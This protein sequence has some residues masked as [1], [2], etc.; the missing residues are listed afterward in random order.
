MFLFILWNDDMFDGGRTDHVR[1][2]EDPTFGSTFSV[3]VGTLNVCCSQSFSSL[4]VIN[5]V[6]V[7]VNSWGWVIRRWIGRS[8]NVD[9]NVGW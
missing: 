4:I 1:E 7:K 8:L 6:V 9:W 2:Y 3:E 5:P